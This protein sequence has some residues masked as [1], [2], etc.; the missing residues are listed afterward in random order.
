[1]KVVIYQT[2]LETRSKVHCYSQLSRGLSAVNFFGFNC[3]GWIWFWSSPSVSSPARLFWDF[4]SLMNSCCSLANW[5]RLLWIAYWPAG[6]CPFLILN[7][8]VDCLCFPREEAGRC[9][10][11]VC[12]HYGQRFSKGLFSVVYCMFGVTPARISYIYKSF[13][14]S[15]KN[16]LI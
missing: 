11:L 16:C 14:R 4:N 5:T 8:L 2:T 3:I 10:A 9:I 6:T 13:V 7:S 15:Y 1:M 12:W